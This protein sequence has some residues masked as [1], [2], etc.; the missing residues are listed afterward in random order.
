MLLFLLCVLVGSC[1]VVLRELAWML[2]LSYSAD[3]GGGGVM[4]PGSVNFGTI[5]DPC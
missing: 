4:M 1:C 5:C 3:L 2:S